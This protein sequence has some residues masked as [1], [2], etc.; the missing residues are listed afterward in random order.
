MGVRS[1][2]D[3]S[4]RSGLDLWLQ[5]ATADPAGPIPGGTALTGGLRVLIGRD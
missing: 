5:G 1:G 4:E 2:F 3:S